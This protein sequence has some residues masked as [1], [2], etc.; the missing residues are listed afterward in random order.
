MSKF[1][2]FVASP[3]IVGAFG[4]VGAGTAF[5]TQPLAPNDNNGGQTGNQA[6]CI[7]AYS[8]QVIHNGPVVST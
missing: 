3:A 4:V 5:A 6:N 2:K 7:A 1:P 8:S